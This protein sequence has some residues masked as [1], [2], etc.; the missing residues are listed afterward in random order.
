MV[1]ACKY[2]SHVEG[3]GSVNDDLQRE[4]ENY[5]RVLIGGDVGREWLGEE[6]DGCAVGKDAFPGRVTNGANEAAMKKA[7][8]I[9][10]AIRIRT[11]PTLFSTHVD[12][13]Q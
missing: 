5:F 4:L 7:R 11:K 1:S 10:I 6:D 8:G 12:S 13:L 3:Y 9:Q 2:S